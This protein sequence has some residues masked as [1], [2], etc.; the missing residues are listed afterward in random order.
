ME[1]I[2]CTKRNL[3]RCMPS[4]CPVLESG[5]LCVKFFKDEASPQLLAVHRLVPRQTG[6]PKVRQGAVISTQ[7]SV[8]RLSSSYGSARGCSCYLDGSPAVRYYYFLPRTGVRAEHLSV[9]HSLTR[10]F[11]RLSI[12]AS[13]LLIQHRAS[14]ETHIQ[15]SAASLYCDLDQPGSAVHVHVHALSLVAHHHRRTSG[16]TH[17]GVCCGLASGKVSVEAAT[18]EDLEAH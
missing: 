4:N 7:V 3:W 13:F 11:A 5:F 1:V 10:P 18:N 6:A 8:V 12:K 14:T 9:P 15:I 17:L 16:A 2:E